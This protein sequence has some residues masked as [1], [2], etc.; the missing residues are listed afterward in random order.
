[1]EL[2]PRPYGHP[3]VVVLTAEVQ[4]HY[5][6]LYGGPGDE[7]RVEVADFEA[8]TGHFLVGY[9]EGVAVAMGGW[10]RLG[11]RPGLPSPNTAEIKRMYVAPRARR[12][13]LSREVLAEL[14]ASARAAGIDWL[15]L[16]TG[17]PQ[18]SAVGLYRS[19]GY[20]EV[21]GT[22]YGHYLGEP[23]VVHLGKSLH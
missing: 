2:I 19:S 17:Q 16:E 5:R 23:D 15:V 20:V 11:A 12:Q 6:E 10:R 9:V 4:A 13:G 7:S 3:D 18:T 21:D 1:V 22:P 14:E 8:P